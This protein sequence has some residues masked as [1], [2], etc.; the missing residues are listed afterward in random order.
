MTSPSGVTTSLSYT[1]DTWL[2]SEVKDTLGRSLSFDYEIVKIKYN[3][4]FGVSNSGGGGSGN[5]MFILEHPIKR[6]KSVTSNTQGTVKY[7]YD[8]SNNLIKVT[9]PDSSTKTYH[10]EDSKNP[11]ALTGM[12]DESGTRIMTYGYD[13]K[14]RAVSEYSP[15][16]DGVNRYALGF[17]GNTTT[18]ADPIGTSRTY[19]FTKINDV[20][21]STGQSQ[22]G[23]S[24]CGPASLS[25]QYDAHG[26]ITRSTAK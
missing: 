3:N 8:D 6:L 2:I 12:T 25:N 20:T 23:G 24:G 1:K 7:D 16:V 9:Y 11:H 26:N 19:Q 10:Y 13:D 21:R 15:A 4:L 17:N 14:G 18:V 22:P 5:M